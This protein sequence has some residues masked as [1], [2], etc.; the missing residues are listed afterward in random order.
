MVGIFGKK[1]DFR[2]FG[3]APHKETIGTFDTEGMAVL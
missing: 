3:L 2:A 1:D